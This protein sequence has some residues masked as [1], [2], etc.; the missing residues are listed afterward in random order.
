MNALDAINKEIDEKVAQLKD[1]L[2]TGNISTLD[3]YKKIC[4]ELKGLL[5]VKEYTLSLKQNL[6]EN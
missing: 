1:H 5:F 4:G 6:E 2:A 3:E